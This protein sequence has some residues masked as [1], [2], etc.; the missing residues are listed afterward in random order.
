MKSP[1]PNRKDSTI[2]ASDVDPVADRDVA[3]GKAVPKRHSARGPTSSPHT[4]PVAYGPAGRARGAGPCN[5]T[6]GQ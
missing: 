2:K 1:T 4:G 6:G 5:K 3:L